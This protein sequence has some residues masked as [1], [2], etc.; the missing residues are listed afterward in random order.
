MAS[1]TLTLNGANG[2]TLADSAQV[3]DRGSTQTITVNGQNTYVYSPGG[4]VYLNSA[5]GAV[6]IEP[7][8][9]VNVSG[10]SEY[11]STDLNDIGVNAGLISIS[12]PNA[13]ANLQGTLLGYAGNFYS[14]NTIVAT[15]IGGSFTLDTANLSNFATTDG[16]TGFSALNEMLASGGF[17]DAL[18]IRSRNDSLV[19]VDTN[20]VVTARQFTLTADQ[21]SIDV[22]GSILTS[23]P[24]GAASVQLYAGGDLTLYSGSVISATGSPQSS[25]NGGQ[26]VLSSTGGTIYFN[27]GATLNVSG[28]GSGQ[29]GSVY[30][31]A[32]VN[33]AGTDV[34]M[35]LAGAITGAKQIV[36]EGY[37]AYSLPVDSTNTA[38]ITDNDITGWQ[39]SIQTFMAGP[40][41]TIQ[42]NLFENL[43]LT[44]ESGPIRTRS[45]DR[46]YGQSDP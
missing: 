32:A 26:I 41:A 25:A 39:D 44:N 43:T 16:K 18:N 7:G 19:T 6:T 11:N 29:G 46:Q 38:Y 24:N 22:K 13:P 40:G 17:N 8:A 10:V 20:D 35:N 2:V 15:G 45:R 12:S 30:F 23:D 27:K 28:D 3:L 1:G 21:G 9:V 33:T 31:R 14:G 4:S 5:S 34:N 37:Q 36:A 42:A